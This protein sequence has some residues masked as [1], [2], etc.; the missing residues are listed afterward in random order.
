MRYNH[1]RSLAGHRKLNTIKS[2]RYIAVNYG[3]LTDKVALI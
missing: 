2:K 3:A 1:T